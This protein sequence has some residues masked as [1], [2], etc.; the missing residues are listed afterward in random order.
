M[1]GVEPLTI[2]QRLGR[3]NV[4]RAL[5]E[6]RT[7]AVYLV[8][9]TLFQERECIKVLAGPMRTQQTLARLHEH[10]LALR[11]VSAPGLCRLLGV[12]QERGVDFL[13][14]GHVAGVSLQQLMKHKK[15]AA[16]RLL[17]LCASAADALA[18][19]HD[20]GIHHGALSAHDVMIRDGDAGG[21]AVCLLGTGV[22][23]A[24]DASARVTLHPDRAA[25]APEVRDGQT[26]TAQSDQYALA[27]LLYQAL[28]GV[29]PNVA[30]VVARPS[31][32]NTELDPAVDAAVLRALSVNPA[33]RHPNLRALSAA[34]SSSLNDATVAVE[35][36]SPITQPSLLRLP[37]FAP[38]PQLKAQARLEQPSSGAKAVPWLGEPHE[39]RAAMAPSTTP[40]SNDTLDDPSWVVAT[41]PV[42][43]PLIAKDMAVTTLSSTA[44]FEMGHKLE[45]RKKRSKLPAIGLGLGVVALGASA[46]VWFVASPQTAMAVDAGPPVVVATARVDAGTI[47]TVPVVDDAA[48]ASKLA[49]T[50]KPKER[51]ELRKQDFD[52]YLASRGLLPDDDAQLEDARSRITRLVQQQRYSQAQQAV[53]EARDR[54]NA[55][56]ID[57][58]FVNAKLSR[59]NRRAHGKGDLVE[60]QM[61]AAEAALKQGDVKA[62][63]AA[64]NAGYQI[65][66]G[67]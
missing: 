30:A 34:L 60:A 7:G 61:Q 17:Q 46:A 5:S 47:A 29:M 9:D 57:E 13:S 66:Q 14:M 23:A 41:R 62:A 51:Y 67:K 26:P 55:I 37:S 53:K 63:N 43:Q 8:D 15:L 59:L 33:A 27:A 65:L 24:C 54:A 35:T 39:A 19:A 32:F 31:A 50:R 64:L 4:L 40:R 21:D 16:A 52:D 2:G 6:G 22:A 36:F 1:V 3:Y 20:V 10:V 58:D 11:T 38:E 25:W 49:Q 48:L 42:G 12:Y 56:V 18:A 44:N 45:L 28:T